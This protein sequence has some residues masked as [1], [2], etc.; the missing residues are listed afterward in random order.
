MNL[1]GKLR[2]KLG[3]GQ[4]R[5]PSKNLGGLWPPLRIATDLHITAAV[6]GPFVSKVA[7]LYITVAV[8]PPES[9]VLY[10]LQL[11][12]G[13]RAKRISCL[14]LNTPLYIIMKM[15][16]Y[17]NM[18]PT[19]HVLLHPICVLSHLMCA[20]KHCNVKLSSYCIE[21]NEVADEFITSK[22]TDF[23]RFFII[24]PI[25]PGRLKKQIWVEKTLSGRPGHMWENAYYRNW[26]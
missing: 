6:G 12:R 4:N 19:E 5:G 3:G 10:T 23:T 13:A 14:P 15:T 9:K 18:K 2:K 1:N 21:H 24:K 22:N 16:L 25:H 17:E 8:G 20:C 26:M 11:Q 7:Y